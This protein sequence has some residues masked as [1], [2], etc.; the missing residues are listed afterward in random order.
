MIS[1]SFNAD[2]TVYET[3]TWTI[4]NAL[5]AADLN[6]RAWLWAE[7]LKHSPLHRSYSHRRRHWPAETTCV[8]CLAWRW[9]HV[10]YRHDTST[11]CH[12]LYHQHQHQWLGS[13][14]IPH[15]LGL[16]IFSSI[17]PILRLVFSSDVE[18]PI[19]HKIWRIWLN[20]SF[21]TNWFTQLQTSTISRSPS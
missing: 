7:R 9:H 10:L 1:T 6:V 8:P 20:C 12:R 17:C 2:Y 4:A 14:T 11:P 18:C 5:M 19:F 16:P 3:E 13:P 15:S 21:T